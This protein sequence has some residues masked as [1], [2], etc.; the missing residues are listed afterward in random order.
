[1]LGL[2]LGLVAEIALLGGLSEPAAWLTILIIT[3]MGSIY[4]INDLTNNNN[5]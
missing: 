1:M 3:L 4:W 2:T 5:N